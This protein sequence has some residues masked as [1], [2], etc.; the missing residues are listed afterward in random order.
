MAPEKQRPTQHIRVHLHTHKLETKGEK[1]KLPQA[2][3]QLSLSDED[4]KC[5]H[6]W[7]ET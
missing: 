2:F 6:V 7:N 4:V 5:A 3:V 1:G